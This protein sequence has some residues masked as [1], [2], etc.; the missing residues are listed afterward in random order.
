LFDGRVG[1]T[2]ETAFLNVG[3]Q[4]AVTDGRHKYIA[5]RPPEQ[6]LASMAAGELDKAPTHVNTFESHQACVA[7]ECYPHYFASDQLYDMAQDPDEQVN[8]IDR[9]ECA[10]IL[11]RLRTQLSIYLDT[12]PDQPFDLVPPAFLQS[13]AYARLSEKTR[14]ARI[15]TVPWWRVGSWTPQARA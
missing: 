3:W 2:R 15:G 4:R 12:F 7:M 11:S 8:L 1:Q 10:E 13:E 14:E 9:P 5:Y 6:V